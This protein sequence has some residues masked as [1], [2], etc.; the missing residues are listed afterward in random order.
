MDTK[1]IFT[2]IIPES[3]LLLT[4]KEIK[5]K[6]FILGIE[7]RINI[8]TEEPSSDAAEWKTDGE[9]FWHLLKYSPLASVEPHENTSKR[10]FREWEKFFLLSATIPNCYSLIPTQLNLKLICFVKLNLQ[11]NC[12]NSSPLHARA[13][14]N[15]IAGFL[16]S[17]WFA[18]CSNWMWS[19]KAECKYLSSKSI[20]DRNIWIMISA[21]R[22][23]AFQTH[24]RHATAFVW[25]KLGELDIKIP[26]WNSRAM[27]KWLLE[28][29]R[30]GGSEF[31]N[32]RWLVRFELDNGFM[33]T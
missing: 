3:F 28:M 1:L 17:G 19:N 29:V 5:M 32:C 27:L 20:N 30:S 18:N 14:L 15:W 11:A 4:S 21:N 31:H 8:S 2:K 24:T 33:L 25:F 6:I 12:W 23:G 9:L 22:L 10:M 13:A 7:T 26:N 16:W